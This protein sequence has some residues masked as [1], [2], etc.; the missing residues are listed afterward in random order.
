MQRFGEQEQRQDVRQENRAAGRPVELVRR[1]LAGEQSAMVELVARY[2]G[3]IYGLCYRMLNQRQDAED[4]AQETFVRA[5][6]NLASWDPTRDFEP[7]LFAIAGNRCRT[8]LA[9][10]KRRPPAQSLGDESPA[11]DEPDLQ[12]ARNLAEEVQL[13]LG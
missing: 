5:L 7:W 10:R 3:P 13:A 6:R 8:M 11:A 4:M 2:Q 9:T 1:C 12:A